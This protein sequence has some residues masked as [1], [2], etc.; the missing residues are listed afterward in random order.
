MP[1]PADLPEFEHPPLNEVVL[2]IQFSPPSGYSQIRAGDVWALFRGDFPQVQEQQILPPTFETFGLPQVPQFNLA[3][4]TGATHD[5]FWFLSESGDE[6]IQFQNDRLLHNWRKVGE[7]KNPYPRFEA[8]V[9]K[10]ESEAATLERYFASLSPQQLMINQCEISYINHIR[11]GDEGEAAR[12]DY[13]LRF[14]KFQD[15]APED[16]AIKF[17][18]RVLSDDGR[19]LG[20]LTCEA[21]SAVENSTGKKLVLL[22]LTAR[23]APETP[24]LAAAL[25]F[26]TKGRQLVVH[27][28][29]ALTTDSAHRV[30][31][32]AR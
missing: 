14:A 18:K 4:A 27:W 20:R 12:P 2:G 15:E 11:L 13:W 23:G 9:Q 21:V 31:G 28:F 19:P 22:T 30:W 8:I 26:L 5:R 24:T 16:Y 7:G 10:F 1:R 17:R 6:L 25:A 32:R 3:I 29:A